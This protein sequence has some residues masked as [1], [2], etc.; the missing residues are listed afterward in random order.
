MCYTVE[1]YN[2]PGTQNW[3]HGII[4]LFGPGWDL[5]TLQPVGQPETQ[6]WSGGEWI[7]VDNI[8]AGITGEFI[9]SPGW[10]FDAGS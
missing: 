3:M 1:Q 5:S 10:F 4:P 2:T 9:N 7:W 8:T 6:F